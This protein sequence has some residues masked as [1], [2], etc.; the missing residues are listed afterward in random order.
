MTNRK[1]LTSAQ[2]QGLAYYSFVSL[3]KEEK[4]KIRAT[5]KYPKLPDP[6]VVS[7]LSIL[8]LIEVCGWNYGPIHK[9]TNLGEELSK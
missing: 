4:S 5:G 8:G 3:P 7:A 6:R 2:T 1:P 9:L